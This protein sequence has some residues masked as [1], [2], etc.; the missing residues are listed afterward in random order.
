MCTEHRFVS[1]VK[2]DIEDIDLFLSSFLLSNLMGLAL[3]NIKN[4]G[5]VLCKKVVWSLSHLR[6]LLNIPFVSTY[7]SANSSINRLFEA[8]N[9]CPLIL[10]NKLANFAN[11]KF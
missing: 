4:L 1:F 2:V 10:L 7:I 3:D 6:I 8:H 11:S 5:S 9:T